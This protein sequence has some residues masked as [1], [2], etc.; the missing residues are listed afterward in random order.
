MGGRK[1]G[2]KDG[3]EE[4]M[5]PDDKIASH[6]SDTFRERERF[7]TFHTAVITD[8]HAHKHPHTIILYEGL[9]R[10]LCEL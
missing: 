4:K 10:T 8:S 9:Q 6:N 2:R 1:K 5:R 7:L 3:Y